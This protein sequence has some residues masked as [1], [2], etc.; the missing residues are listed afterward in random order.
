[1]C[2]LNSIVPEMWSVP[3]VYLTGLVIFNSWIVSVIGTCVAA[4]VSGFS[5]HLRQI[6][7]QTDNF[8]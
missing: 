2:A 3:E 6:D 4:C 8:I 5:S 7:R 1:M